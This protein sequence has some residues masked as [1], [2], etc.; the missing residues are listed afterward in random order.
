[1]RS[2][3]PATGLPAGIMYIVMPIASIPMIYDSLMELL[4][5]EKGD[6]KLEDR[7]KKEAGNHA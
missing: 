4:G 7:M 6:E 1:M 5:I 2:I 3:L